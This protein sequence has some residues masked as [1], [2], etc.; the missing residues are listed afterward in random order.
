MNDINFL[1]DDEI[2]SKV[3]ELMNRLK[4]NQAL[5]ELTEK[6]GLNIKNSVK[7]TDESANN[8]AISVISLLLAKRS[9]DP[10]YRKLTQMGLQKRSLKTEIINDYKNQAICKA[11]SNFY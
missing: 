2:F 8:I 1:N 11:N 6:N 7:L 3:T 4:K 5:Q 10:R 9:S